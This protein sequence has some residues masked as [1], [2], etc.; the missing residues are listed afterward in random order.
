L[1]VIYH[2]QF[3]KFGHKI[4]HLRVESIYSIKRSTTFHAPFSRNSYILKSITY[5]LSTPNLR[6]NRSKNVESKGR[7]SFT[8][9]RVTN[10]ADCLKIQACLTTFYKERLY[11]TA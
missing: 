9:L 3:H 4:W 10:W 2:T 6:P 8:P 1:R 5:I 11:R 7:N